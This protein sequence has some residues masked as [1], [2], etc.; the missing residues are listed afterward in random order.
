M[1]IPKVTIK[2]LMI[3]VLILA[4]D[5]FLIVEVFYGVFLPILTLNFGLIQILRP[6]TRKR[7]F[8]VGSMVTGLVLLA[9]HVGLALNDEEFYGQWPSDVLNFVLGL[10]TLYLSPETQ[11]SVA[12]YLGRFL[13]LL[14]D[15]IGANVF[16][17]VVFE[18][19][20]G[21]PLVVLATI[22]GWFWKRLG[23][24][25][26]ASPEPDETVTF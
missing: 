25:P 8:W 16:L 12:P 9:V 6:R 1:R 19:T 3:A 15:P 4:V 24:R 20:I 11:I 22:G 10:V 17:I 14:N 7:R 23:P 21:L 13:S 18:T 2:G 26:V 5:C